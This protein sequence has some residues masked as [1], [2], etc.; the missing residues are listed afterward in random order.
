MQ[1]W[2]RVLHIFTAAC[3]GLLSL[4]YLRCRYIEYQLLM[5]VRALLSP[6][7]CDPTWHVSSRSDE[8]GLHSLANRY[9]AGVYL[10]LLFTV[11]VWHKKLPSVL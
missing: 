11:I 3:L 1:L 2:A 10:L 5:G 7:P 8:V 9:I 6:L 4:A